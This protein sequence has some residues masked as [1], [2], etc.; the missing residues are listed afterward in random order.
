MPKRLAVALIDDDVA[1]LLSTQD[2]LTRQGMAVS[3]FET[4]EAFLAGF[5]KPKPA[6]NC[7]VSDVRMPGLSGLELMDELKRQGQQVPVI[8]ITGHGDVRMAVQAIKAGAFDFIEKPFDVDELAKA[9]E[10]AAAA[11]K[12][13]EEFLQVRQ[14]VAESVARLS[15]RQRQV[16]DFVVEGHSSRQIAEKL[17]ISTRTVETYRLQIMEKMGA[18]SV[19]A[20]VRM[21][22]MIGDDKP[23]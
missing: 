1:V 9:I 10:R 13:N 4:A 3:S 8:L 22:S 2:L 21:V 19:A 20:L 6:L 12:A 18:G 23:G 5:G 11:S 7:I 17:G 16:M 14:A 15:A